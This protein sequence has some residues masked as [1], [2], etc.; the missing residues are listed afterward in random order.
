VEH[1]KARKEDRT[2]DHKQW[3]ANRA[4]REKKH[5]REQPVYQKGALLGFLGAVG[6]SDRI[7]EWSPGDPGGA[8]REELGAP[9]VSQTE[10][11]TV[12]VRLSVV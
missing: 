1:H 12:L 6:P 9:W 8:Q 7:K 3:S 2:S 5:Q 4:R 11:F 10:F